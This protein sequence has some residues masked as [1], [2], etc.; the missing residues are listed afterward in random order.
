[1][2]DRFKDTETVD[3]NLFICGKCTATKWK[4]IGY[5][6][7]EKMQSHLFLQKFDVMLQ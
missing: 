4:C 5:V 2:I 1:M 6:S 3:L 7:I